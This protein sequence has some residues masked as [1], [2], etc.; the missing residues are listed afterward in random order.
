M[1]FY[2]V[3]LYGVNFVLPHSMSAKNKIKFLIFTAASPKDFQLLTDFI[4]ALSSVQCKIPGF[5][6]GSMPPVMDVQRPSLQVLDQFLEPRI[7]K[8]K[9][10]K[11]QSLRIQVWG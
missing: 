4:W 1:I 3:I 6:G 9:R 5:Q 7:Q 2:K 10:A 11:H 8:L